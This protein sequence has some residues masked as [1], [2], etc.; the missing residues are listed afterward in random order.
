MTVRPLVLV[1]SLTGAA[2]ALAQ[3]AAPNFPVLPPPAMGAAAATE[4]APIDRVL[5]GDWRSEAN[6]ARDAYRHPRETLA[7]L[8]VQPGQRLIEV[9]PG[10]GWYAEVLAPLLRSQGQYTAAVPRPGKPG[11]NT[12]KANDK[13]RATFAAAPAVYGTPAV[14]EVDPKAPVLG[15][16]G[17][18]DVVLTFRNAH[19]WVMAGNEAAMFKAFFAVLKPG[20]VLGVVDHRARPDQP[21]AEMK[22]SGY[23]PQA[24][25]VKLAEA[26]GFRLEEASEVNANPRDTKDYADGVWTLPP[27]LALGEKDRAKY[28]AIGESDRMTLRFTKP[29][30]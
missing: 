16:P 23:L 8:G 28:Q 30:P 26:A 21:A 2:S 22:S 13:L 20:G 24:Y 29:G 1:L 17:S 12:A 11:D 10:G 7:F 9:W 27:A 25:V 3:D 14:V 19:N 5:A 6:K 18:A 15:A 4:A